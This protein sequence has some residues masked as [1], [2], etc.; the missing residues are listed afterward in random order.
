VGR[1]P[2][3]QSLD[4][5]L[6]GPGALDVP[7]GIHPILLEHPSGEG[8][9]GAKGVAEVSLVGV[10]PAV[11]NAIRHATGATVTRIPA[12]GERVLRALLAR[13]ETGSKG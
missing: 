4:E 9:F 1:G 12:T 13:E 10:A 2:P 8:P 6:Q 3:A 7:V 11:C 5:R